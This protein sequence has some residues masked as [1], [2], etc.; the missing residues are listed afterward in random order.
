[1]KQKNFRSLG[2]DS[3][4]GGG[5]GV[6]IALSKREGSK[7]GRGGKKVPERGGTGVNGPTSTQRLVLKCSKQLYF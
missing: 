4:S 7:W 5:K 3:V 1:M 6:I 2:P